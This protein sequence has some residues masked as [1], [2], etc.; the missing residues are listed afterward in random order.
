VVGVDGVLVR[1]IGAAVLSYPSSVACT[2]YDELVVVDGGN[3]RLLLFD[4][5][6]EMLLSFGSGVFN[7][8]TI[9]DGSIFARTCARVDV[10]GECVVF[11]P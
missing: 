8:V 9:R 2:D 10:G 7:A 3:L 1:H 11:T 4:A 5:M 6:G